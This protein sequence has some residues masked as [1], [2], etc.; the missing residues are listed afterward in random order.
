MTDTSGGEI[1]AIDVGQGA[2]NPAAGGEDIDAE[3]R[4][5]LV[6][7]LDPSRNPAGRQQV[8]KAADLGRKIRRVGRAQTCARVDMAAGRSIS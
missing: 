7:G 2:A 3:R 8:D 6:R 5:R 4:I 1:P